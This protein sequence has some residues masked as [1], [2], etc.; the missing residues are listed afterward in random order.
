MT[1]IQLDRSVDN[2]PWAT[3]PERFGDRAANR[4]RLSTGSH[5]VLEL[6][7]TIARVLE[8]SEVIGLTRIADLTDLDV[9]GIPNYATICPELNQPPTPGGISVMSGKGLTR[10][11]ALASALMEAVERHAGLQD[12]RP[13]IRGSWAQLS[14]HHNVLHPTSYVVPESFRIGD[15]D[16]LDWVAAR[17]LFRQDTVLVPACT[18]FVPYE[19]TAATIADR[20]SSSNGLASGNT[21]EEATLHAIYE[22][23]ERDAESF[24]VQT[25]QVRDVDLTQ[26]P[27]PEVRELA[28]RFEEAGLNLRVKDI[29]GP[30]PVPTFLATALDPS[31]PATMYANGGKGTHL[32]PRVAMTRA[33]CEVAQ[34]RV[35]GMSGIREDMVAKRGNMAATTVEALVAEYPEWY[36]PCEETVDVSTFEDRSTANSVDDLKVV[37]EDLTRAGIPDVAVVD[38]TRPEAG[39][40]VARACVPLMEFEGKGNWMGPRLARALGELD[41]DGT[42]APAARLGASSGVTVGAVNGSSNGSSPNGQSTPSVTRHAGPRIRVF[43]GPSLPVEEAR[44]ILDA[45]YRPPIRDGD[46]EAAMADGVE[47]IGIIDAAFIQGYTATPTQILEALRSGV[48]IFGAAS[49]GALRAV[50]LDRYGLRG[51]GEIYHL[52]RSGFDAED[53]LAV[54][55]DPDSGR[56]LTEAMINVRSVCAGAR[57]DGIIDSDDHDRLV[58]AAKGV[59][60]AHRTYP[61]IGRAASEVEPEVRDRFVA[62]A[63]EHRDRLNRKAADARAC[64]AQIA[65]YAAAV[66]AR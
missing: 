12:R 16:Q 7:D 56:S 17:S 33:I 43:L 66:A 36:G 57:D 32:D 50:E 60:F 49:A 38:L 14:R 42:G 27:W 58:E 8:R 13:T 46:I 4:K 19:P 52:Y 65:A 35:V 20:P 1:M 2:S 9:L 48:V 64:L 41:G 53:E 59:Y 54:A 23:I 25:R 61:A 62:W 34:S 55:F 47:V 10:A 24:A 28:A 31:L 30:I 5:R 40:P 21:I 11:H 6:E 26:V 37:L 29:T 15:D 45:D 63:L 3:V 39:I 18:V 44:E 51:V 22:L